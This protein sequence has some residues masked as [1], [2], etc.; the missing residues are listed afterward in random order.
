MSQVRELMFVSETPVRSA[1]PLI[2][3]VQPGAPGRQQRPTS[4]P[5][6]YRAE[7]PVCDQLP[8]VRGARF[9]GAATAAAGRLPTVAMLD[10]LTASRRVAVG[11]ARKLTSPAV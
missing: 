10:P 1:V 2:A 3:A 5:T 7:T 6:Y 4:G 11:Q 8:A 9:F